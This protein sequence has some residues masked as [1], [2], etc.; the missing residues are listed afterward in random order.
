MVFQPNLLEKSYFIAKMSGLAAGS[1]RAQFWLLESALSF[2]NEIVSHS[3]REWARSFSLGHSSIRS[4]FVLWVCLGRVAV[5][6]IAVKIN[7]I[8][9][10]IKTEG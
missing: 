10:P 3:K 8:A 2:D 7:W 6:A 4:G 5:G 1:G 9:L